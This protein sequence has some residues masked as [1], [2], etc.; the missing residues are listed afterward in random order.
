MENSR[1]KTRLSKRERIAVLFQVETTLD[2]YCRVCPYIGGNTPHK[3]CRSCPVNGQLQEYGRQLGW[4]ESPNKPGKH[5][6][7]T[8]EEDLYLRNSFGKITVVKMSKELKRSY[9]SVT[10]RINK[11]REKGVL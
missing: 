9:N 6:P 8:D 2:T 4:E 10:K 3:N 1:K 7:W 5:I 11:L